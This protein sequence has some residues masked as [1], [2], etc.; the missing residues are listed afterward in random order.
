MA[1]AP[2]AAGG[3]NST[4]KT[5]AVAGKGGTAVANWQQEMEAD[6]QVAVASEAT[7][8]GGG[9][10]FFGLRAGVLSFDD[11]TFPGN[12][13]CVVIVD[14]IMENIFYEG[15]FDPEN[16]NPPTCY[17]FGRDAKTMGP[18]STVDE[19]PEFTR[20]SDICDNCIQNEWGS[21]EKGRGKAC[22]NRRRLAL[23]SAGTYKPQGRGGTGG[24]EL[25]LEDDASHFAQTDM[26]FLKIPVMSVK[27][28]SAYVK[29]VADQ[30]NRPL[31]GVIT[32]IYIEPDPK[33]QF[34]VRFEM[35]D[36]VPDE[37]MP[38]LY[39]RHK[40]IKDEIDFPYLPRADD[41]EEQKPARSNNKL[42]G[43]T[44]KKAASKGRR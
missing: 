12:Q 32:R 14:H 1:R 8:G 19:H 16:K 30:F 18:P 24:F 26:A 33:S 3:G 15:D 41:E 13:I 42:R 4:A 35:I 39:A 2:K 27:G 36:L 44:K 9:G 29:Q 23:V 37:L 25:E 10:R 11:A 28:F 5:K 22:S 6:A 17:A 43:G 21:A 40:G 34:R 31:Y 20:Q 38:A 7:A